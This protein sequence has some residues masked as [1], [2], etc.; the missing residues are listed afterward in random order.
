M[1]F[2]PPRSCWA[3]P[4]PQHL[5][6]GPSTQTGGRAEGSPGSNTKTLE[7]VGPADGGTSQPP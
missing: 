5:F 3:L 2:P 4:L 1:G 6:L 7:M